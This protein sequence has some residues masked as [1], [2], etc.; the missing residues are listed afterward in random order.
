M[1]GTTQKYRNFVAEPMGEKSVTELAGI[2]ETLGGRLI[3]AGF[4]KVNT[5]CDDA[6]CRNVYLMTL[7]ILILNFAGLHC[8]WPV[9]GAEKRPG[10]VQGLDE[11]RVPCQFKAG[12]GLLQLPQRLVRGVLVNGNRIM[13]ICGNSLDKQYARTP[14]GSS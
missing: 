12:V 14:Q 9:F 5:R 7:Y 2:G 1:S 6:M 10:V 4:D 3:E 13:E 8:A 11:G